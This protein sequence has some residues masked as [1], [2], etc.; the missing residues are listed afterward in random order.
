M[1]VSPMERQ[2]LRLLHRARNP[3][4]LAAMSVPVGALEQI[5]NDALSGDDA[6]TENLRRAIFEADFKRSATNA[7][8]ARRSGVSLRHFQRWR[9]EAVASIAQHAAGS[10]GSIQAPRPPRTGPCW[11]FRREVAA[12]VAARDRGNALEMRC[13]ATNLMR[14]AG[15]AETQALARAYLG[16]ANRR[17][18]ITEE[19]LALDLGVPRVRGSRCWRRIARD[20]E[21]AAQLVLQD[22][23]PQAE[24]L[25]SPAWQRCELRGFQG[26][27]ARCAAVLCAT[28]EARAAFDEACLWRARS[29]ERLLPTQDR[30]LAADLFLHPAYG[31]GCRMDRA[32]SDVLYERLR[33]IL[34]Q[35]LGDG[36]PQRAAVTELLDELL[37]ARVSSRAIVSVARCDSAFAHYIERNVEPVAEMLA[38]ALAALTATTFD[39][40]LV[41]LHCALA[42]C[43]SKLRPAV[44][45]TIAIAVPESQPAPT[46]HLKFDDQRSGSVEYPAGLHIRFLPFRSDAGAAHARRRRDPVAGPPGAVAGS[47]HSR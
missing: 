8:L 36:V 30:L 29:I 44:P 32:L 25:A 21:R 31:P 9:A 39:A 7:E 12:F 27:A 24:A 15:D 2:V 41:S 17:L 37:D 38:L 23:I 26:L 18:G 40:A 5:V 35:M 11:R 13:I 46:E 3:G 22:R 28:A 47:A 42:D 19:R 33:V 6:R 45:R 14:L 1:A 20:V 34:P 4:A 43:A 10:L 16:D